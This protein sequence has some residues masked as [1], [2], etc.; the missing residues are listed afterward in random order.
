M[1]GQGSCGVIL[2]E[3][4]EQASF[5]F[6]KTI[7]FPAGMGTLYFPTTVVNLAM[8]PVALMSFPVVR[9]MIFCFRL[10]LAPPPSRL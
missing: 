6:E 10:E 9:A 8:R 3:A 7:G 2:L 5:D 1:A 4:I